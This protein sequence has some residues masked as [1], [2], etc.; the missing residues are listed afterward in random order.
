M[1]NLLFLCLMYTPFTASAVSFSV[2]WD[3]ECG[4]QKTIDITD[5]QW[6]FITTPLTSKATSAK[7]ERQYIRQSIARFEQ[8][9]GR[10]TGTDKDI[11]EN[12]EGAGDPG[13]MDCIDESTNST[14]Y[15]KLLA[16]RQLLTFHQVEEPQVRNK[17]IFDVHWAA[18]ISESSNRQKFAVDS[19]FLDNGHPP[20][21]Q[22]LDAWKNNDDFD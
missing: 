19:W 4:I 15:L 2:C 13:Q 10:I 21:I 3:Y 14:T 12:A 22:A 16:Q 17:W 8:V 9:V 11:A 20:Y 6:I 7:Q 18:V 5:E 1:R